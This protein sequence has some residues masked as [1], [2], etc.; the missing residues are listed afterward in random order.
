M[1]NNMFTPTISFIMIATTDDLRNNREE[2]AEVVTLDDGL[3]H[4]G[5]EVIMLLVSFLVP[6]YLRAAAAIF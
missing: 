5:V 3:R 2:V 1:I 4:R 6:Y